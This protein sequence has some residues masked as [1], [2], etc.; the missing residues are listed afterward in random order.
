METASNLYLAIVHYYQET[1]VFPKTFTGEAI[2]IFSD[3]FGLDKPLLHTYTVDDEG[4]FSLYEN[5]TNN[6]N[7]EFNLTPCDRTKIEHMTINKLM[8]SH[9]LKYKNK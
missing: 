8:R 1:G 3:P 2:Q 6:W 9:V 5:A 7:T 4:V